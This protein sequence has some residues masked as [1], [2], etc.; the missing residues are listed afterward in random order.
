MGYK[1]VGTTETKTNGLRCVEAE[2]LI[3]Q[4]GDLSF[5]LYPS[6]TCV[7]NAVIHGARR[8]YS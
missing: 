6:F 8:G 4:N 2:K 1:N 3:E 5:S 7:Y